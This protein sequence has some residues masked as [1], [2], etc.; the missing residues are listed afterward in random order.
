MCFLTEDT[1]QDDINENKTNITALQRKIAALERESAALRA[2]VDRTE[3]DT[4]TLKFLRT[5]ELALRKD[6]TAGPALRTERNILLQA[7]T[8]T[9]GSLCIPPTS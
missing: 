5:K 7:T 1:V 8:T 3:D 4:E 9:S 6:I 2:K